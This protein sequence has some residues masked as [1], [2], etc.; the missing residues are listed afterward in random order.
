MQLTLHIPRPNQNWD[1]IHGILVQRSATK[2]TV[3][4]S[5]FSIVFAK[6]RQLK[7]FGCRKFQPRSVT[8]LPMQLSNRQM[9]PATTF[10]E[11]GRQRSGQWGICMFRKNSKSSAFFD[12]KWPEN[13]FLQK[14][15]QHAAQ[16]KSVPSISAKILAFPNLL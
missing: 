16:L 7:I 2:C 8:T 11:N 10:V 12:E 6:T 1:A 5:A 15:S 14:L 9:D 13:Y 4:I 3:K